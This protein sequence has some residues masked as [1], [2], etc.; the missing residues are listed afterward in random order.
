[1]LMHIVSTKSKLR[2]QQSKKTYSTV[3]RFLSN[4]RRHLRPLSTFST[5]KAHQ[6]LK[7]KMVARMDRG[8]SRNTK[9]H[10]CIILARIKQNPFV[11]HVNAY[12]FKQIQTNH[13][14]LG[15]VSEKASYHRTMQRTKCRLFQRSVSKERKQIEINYTQERGTAK[16]KYQDSHGNVNRTRDAIH[17]HAS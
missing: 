12:C 13:P 4:Q 8:T 6:P 17:H 15:L 14:R 5:I 1:M 3:H 16:Q 10:Q 2:Y 7:A 9:T 11:N